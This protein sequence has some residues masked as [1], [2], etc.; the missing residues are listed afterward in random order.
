MCLYMEFMIALA[1]Y[2]L[3][4]GNLFWSYVRAALV[5]ARNPSPS[6]SGSNAAFCHGGRDWTKNLASILASGKY[7]AASSWRFFESFNL[8]GM[9]IQAVFMF[10]KSFPQLLHNLWQ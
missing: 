3:G 1:K 7:S 4:Y 9:F 2:A 10:Q 5:R 8:F 6:R